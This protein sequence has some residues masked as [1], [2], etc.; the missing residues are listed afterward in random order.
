MQ[1]HDVDPD[2]NRFLELLGFGEATARELISRLVVGDGDA[3]RYDRTA[4]TD[5]AMRFIG[6]AY[7]DHRSQYK[8]ML[9]INLAEVRCIS[10]SYLLN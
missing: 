1:N 6:V 8:K 4:L 10:S 7:G 5:P 2:G 3:E 9:C